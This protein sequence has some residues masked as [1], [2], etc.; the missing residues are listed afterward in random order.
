M[1]PALHVG[2]SP[3]CR[4]G[5]GRYLLDTVFSP[6]SLRSSGKATIEVRPCGL[7]LMGPF[8][9]NGN[10]YHSSKSVCRIS[11]LPEILSGMS[12]DKTRKGFSRGVVIVILSVII[13][14]NPGGIST[15]FYRSV[16]SIPSLGNGYVQRFTHSS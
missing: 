5:A 3:G 16:N 2:S 1:P 14:G 8:V 15:P 6:D 12:H 13:T 10:S 7:T 4:R 11:G 9:V